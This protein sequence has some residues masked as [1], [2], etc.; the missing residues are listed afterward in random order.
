MTDQTDLPAEKV[1]EAPPETR[2]SLWLI[3]FGPTIWAAHFVLSYVTAAVWCAK[4]AGRTG[5]LGD[6]R[7][8]I[9]AYTVVALIGIGVT[10]VRGWKRHHF[11]TASVPHDF[12][13]PEDRHRFLGFATLLLCGLSFVAT[14]FV[15]LSVVFIRSCE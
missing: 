7:L 4:I 3:T 14:V 1:P 8:L 10:G 9:G 13:T 15:M 2:E 6:A 11:G 12:D 5:L